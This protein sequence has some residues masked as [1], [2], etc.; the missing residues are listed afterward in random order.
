MCLSASHNPNN[1]TTIPKPQAILHL[2]EDEDDLHS[3][4]LTR[5]MMRVVRQSFGG[6]DAMYAQREREQAPIVS[7]L[8]IHTH[9]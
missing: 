6:M 8:C 5:T 2:L 3:L 9:P 4:H 1:N 7:F